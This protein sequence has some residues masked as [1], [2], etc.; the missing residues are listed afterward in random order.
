MQHR[1]AFTPWDDAPAGTR[2]YDPSQDYCYTDAAADFEAGSSQYFTRA[3]TAILRGGAT[4]YRCGWIKLE[5]TGVVHTILT[6]LS[7]NDGHAVRVTSGNVLEVEVGTGSAT[8]TAT[9]ATTL[10]AATWY[11]WE[12]QY[13]GTDVGIALNG[14]AFTTTTTSFSAGTA[15]FRIGSTVAGGSYFDGLQ[16]MVGGGDGNP[17]A[18]ERSNIYNAGSGVTRSTLESELDDVAGFIFPLHERTGA[19]VDT[20]GA[21]ELTRTNSPTV[22]VGKIEDTCVDRAPCKKWE[23]RTANGDDLTQSNIVYQP[24]WREDADGSGNPGFN[25][26]AN[27]FDT[28]GVYLDLPDW[29]GWTAAEICA[30]IQSAADPAAAQA[31]SGIWTVGSSGSADHHPWTDSNV[32]Q[33]FA[34][35]TRKSMGNFTADLSNVHVFTVLSKSAEQTAR[36]DGT[37]EYTTGTNT[38]GITASGRYGSSSDGAANYGIWCGFA[39][40]NAEFTSAY[41]TGCEGYYKT[42]HGI[43]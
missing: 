21:L 32:Y 11:F 43:S 12:A 42:L 3:S 24:E 20:V 17:S 31:S 16:Q 28:R 7:G 13:D 6:T 14:G 15:A 30:V 4:W 18:G 25:G 38:V 40:R 34:S 29:S 10:S 35:T 33:G 1:S 9:H 26:E 22:A 5:S 27:S 23:E 8:N 19:A 2:V 39:I 37:Q 36:V 41:R